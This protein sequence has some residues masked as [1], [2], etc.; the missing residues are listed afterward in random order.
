M[1]TKIFGSENVTTTASKS[2]NILSDL[3]RRSL[4]FFFDKTILIK[5][6]DY[7]FISYLAM[8]LRVFASLIQ[9]MACACNTFSVSSHFISLF[10]NI[11][12]H[13][14]FCGAYLQSKKEHH[15]IYHTFHKDH[16]SGLD[17]NI[18]PWNL[19]YKLLIN[20]LLKQKILTISIELTFP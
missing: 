11:S 6:Y 9:T 19:I 12:D 15:E 4:C 20:K 3:K 5:Q 16:G 13:F 1:K 17:I 10:Q 18:S 8:T 7:I 14:L 2:S